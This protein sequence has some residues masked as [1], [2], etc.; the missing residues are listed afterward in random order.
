MNL[1]IK[2]I[3]Y[4]EDPKGTANNVITVAS[5]ASVASASSNKNCDIYIKDHLDII[6]VSSKIKTIIHYNHNFKNKVIFNLENLDRKFIEAFIYR[7]LQEITHLINIRNL[8][9]NM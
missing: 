3:K 9:G 4:P 6:N 7:I 5:A 2:D 1:F 8:K